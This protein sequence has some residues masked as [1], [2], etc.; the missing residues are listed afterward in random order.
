MKAEMEKSKI[1]T[2][3]RSEGKSQ[4]RVGFTD[5]HYQRLCLQ[6]SQRRAKLHLFCRMQRRIQAINL[7]SLTSTSSQCCRRH[8][9]RAGDETGPLTCQLPQWG[10]SLENMLEFPVR[11]A[12]CRQVGCRLCRLWTR[13][14]HLKDQCFCRIVILTDQHTP[15]DP[16][17]GVELF[18]VEMDTDRLGRLA[19]WKLLC[20]LTPGSWLGWSS[21]PISSGLSSRLA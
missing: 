21:A 2:L 14:C 19:V 18:R 3:C 7:F 12:G 5:R 1:P 8:I 11:M 15:F 20:T 13:T 17:I 6:H 4:S 9:L 16:D 10:A